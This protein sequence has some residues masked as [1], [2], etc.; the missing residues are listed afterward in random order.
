M[1]GTCSYESLTSVPRRVMIVTNH[2][3]VAMRAPVLLLLFRGADR[4]RERVAAGDDA[5]A[6]AHAAG[7]DAVIV[8]GGSCEAGVG[9]DGGNVSHAGDGFGAGGGR[10]SVDVAARATSQN[11]EAPKRPGRRTPGPKEAGTQGGRHVGP[12]PLAAPRFFR[13]DQQDETTLGARRVSVLATPPAI[14]G[15]E[16]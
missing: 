14:L 6:A 11:A 4:P 7:V 2:Q 3:E 1:L 12:N 15:R 13:F 9:G 8:A 16:S 10:D 5:S